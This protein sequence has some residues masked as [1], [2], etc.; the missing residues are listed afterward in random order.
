MASKGLYIQMFS[1]HGL[2][3]SENMELGRDA[4][5]G[6]QIKYVIELATALSQ[7]DAVRQVELFT[8]LISDKAVSK[9]YAK[10]IE[11]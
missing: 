2:L 3:R 5:T 10:P 4:D 9:D 8:R 11:Q 7:H 6:G 1:V